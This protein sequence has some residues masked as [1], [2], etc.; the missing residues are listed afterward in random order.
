MRKIINVMLLIFLATA[1]LSSVYAFGIL[2]SRQ[3][4][5][6]KDDIDQTF[7]FKIINSEHRDFELKIYPRGELSE[8]VKI[9][10]DKLKIKS[11]E[12]SLVVEIKANIPYSERKP[13][14][15]TINIVVEEVPTEISSTTAVVA[16]LAVPHQLV[17]NAP[18]EGK[19]L[20]AAITSD[21]TNNVKLTVL[22]S[23]DGPEEISK[24]VVEIQIL[25]E[26]KKIAYSTKKT[27]ERLSAGKRISQI[28]TVD[29]EIPVGRYT[30]FSRIKYA[31]KTIEQLEPLVVGKPY[32]EIE[33]IGANK[34]VL[35]G[36]NEIEVSAYNVWAYEL[37]TSGTI[38][39]FDENNKEIAT[40]NLAKK[41]IPPFE[42]KMMSGYW[43]T[44]SVKE[45]NYTMLV[46]LK[47]E[48]NSN[49]KK[50]DIQVSK[51]GMTS[52][53]GISG[54]AVEGKNKGAPSLLVLFIVIVILIIINIFL[55][56]YLRKNKE[57]V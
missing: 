33:G 49:E 7:S 57:Q 38:F 28:I 6:F 16:K 18:V 22:L 15:N 36:I 54:S 37:V 11:D 5:D 39:V 27:F 2:P 45:G 24:T 41:L 12:E 20:S 53:A 29:K 30:L 55:I 51:S 34:F 4:V 25:D 10:K 52:M 26:N 42:G 21:T 50:F 14:M 19:Y 31:D 23:N 13:G 56:K 35:G 1:M 40:F 9:K 43:D 8:Y 47:Y 32:I 3:V 46:Q 48:D 17:L 44:K